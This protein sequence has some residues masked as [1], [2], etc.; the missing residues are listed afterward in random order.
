MGTCRPR[1]PAWFPRG[2][3][4]ILMLAALAALYGLARGGTL[5]SLAATTFRHVWILIVGLVLQVSLD[6][7]DPAW[8]SDNGDLAVIILTNATVA[9]FLALNWRLPGMWLAAL[10]MFLN[11]VVISANGAMPVSAK[12]TEVA[13]FEKFADFGIK[14][15]PLTSDTILPFLADV[16]A[17]PRMRTL[18]SF[19]DVFM[20]AGIFWLVFIR[21]SE[22]RKPEEGKKPSKSEAAG[23]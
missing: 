16:I 9:L 11:L 6:I 7:W 5:E 1:V 17:L 19:G 13:G 14:H 4:F 3:I 18:L 22:G 2:V 12:A 20:A 23:G 10:G 8:L 21:T 15:E